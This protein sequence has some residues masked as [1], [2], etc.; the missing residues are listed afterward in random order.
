MRCREP[1]EFRLAKRLVYKSDNYIQ[2]NVILKSVTETSDEEIKLRL[3][4][5]DKIFI[6]LFVYLQDSS[7]RGLDN[8]ITHRASSTTRSRKNNNAYTYNNDNAL[9]TTE[10]AITN[11]IGANIDKRINNTFDRESWS[12]AD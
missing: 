7:S 5:K 9:E 1:I 4:G 11:R 2:K 10:T 12:M 8:K 6:Y 3:R